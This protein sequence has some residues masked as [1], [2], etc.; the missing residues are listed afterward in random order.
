MWTRGEARTRLLVCFS[1]AV[2]TGCQPTERNFVGESTNGA[3][4][5]LVRIGASELR[6]EWTFRNPRDAPVLIATAFA[7]EDLNPT[8][9]INLHYWVDGTLTLALFDPSPTSARLHL[10]HPDEPHAH[11]PCK[12]L[13][14]EVVPAQGTLTWTT[15][16]ALPVHVG[17][18]GAAI[19]PVA[20]LRMGV[21]LPRFS[22]LSLHTT[23]LQS[24]EANQSV[25]DSV[26][27][28]ERRG[29]RLWVK[30]AWECAQHVVESKVSA[31]ML[32]CDFEE[33]WPNVACSSALN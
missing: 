6:I 14:F 29:N 32:R 18:F 31:S 4:T 26:Q 1:M 27:I 2:C 10:F 5:S 33:P 23:L 16:V 15:T 19:E 11:D 7:D 25:F 12:F 13:L 22:A 8:T 3:L 24:R 9:C 17:H 21:V 20:G 28:L 30:P